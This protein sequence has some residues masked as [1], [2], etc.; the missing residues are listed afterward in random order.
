MIINMRPVTVHELPEIVTLIEEKHFLQ[1]LEHQMEADRPHLVLDC[2]HLRQMSGEAL[3]LL[4]SC[5]EEALKRNGDVKLAGLQPEARAALQL[6]GARRLFETYAT[7]AE[8]V[9]SYEHAATPT[10]PWE[11]GLDMDE[12]AHGPEQVMFID[13]TPATSPKE[14]Q[15]R[16]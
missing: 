9:R 7:T 11:L 6:A 16:R 10:A 14:G 1:S 4:L 5:L 15:G 2:S 3:H 13:R 12:R 8:A